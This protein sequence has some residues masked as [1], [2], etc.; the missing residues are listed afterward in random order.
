[1]APPKSASSPSVLIVDQSEDSREALR[2]V[3][4]L[5][6]VEI[7]EANAGPQ[8]LKLARDHHPDVIVLDV[9][10]S[11]ANDELCDEYA[12]QADTDRTSLVLLGTA[13]RWRGRKPDEFVSKPYQYGPLIRRIEE[14]LAESIQSPPRRQRGEA[15]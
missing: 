1:M 2:R 9:D 13:R 6:G 15:A 8:G 10:G 3:L 11:D 7:L 4:Q 14:L 5:R 12:H